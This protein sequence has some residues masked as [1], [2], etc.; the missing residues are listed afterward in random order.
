MTDMYNSLTVV[1][2]ADIREDDAAPLI[3]AI[4]QL[5]GIASV[6]GNI[7]DIATYSARS[8]ARNE[9]RVSLWN[10]LYPEV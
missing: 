6:E 7:T 9:L 3:D 8:R 4:K 1:L 2:E 5:R 10:V